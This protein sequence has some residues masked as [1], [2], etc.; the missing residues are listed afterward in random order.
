MP[1][2]S[3]TYGTNEITI[4][5]PGDYEITYNAILTSSDAGTV[6]L[7]VRNSDENITSTIESVSLQAGNTL[8]YTGNVITTLE[9]GDTIDMAISSTAG[10]GTVTLTSTSNSVPATLT[11]KKIS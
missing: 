8:N 6:T 11:V 1:N 10:S 2:S 3:V 4:T 5:E 7:A 9:A